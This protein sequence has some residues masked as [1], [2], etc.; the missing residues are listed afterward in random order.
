MA[1]VRLPEWL[2]EAE[3]GPCPSGAGKASRGFAEKNLEVIASFLSGVFTSGEYA[4]GP[5][6]L[7]SVD[8]RARISGVVALVAACAFTSRAAFLAIEFFVI[9]VIAVASNLSLGAV[10]KRVLPSF[11]FTSVLI[12]PAL[13]DFVTPGADI[14]GVTVGGARVS[15]TREGISTAL[16]FLARAAAMVS[17]AAILALTTRHSDFFRGLNGLFIPS[18]FVA[19]LFMAFRYLL[20]LLKTAQDMS[21]ARKSRMIGADDLAGSRGWFSYRAALILKKSMGLS[22]EVNMAMVSRGF[23]GKVRTFE[24]PSL[25]GRDYAWVGFT[26]FMLFISFGL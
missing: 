24:G 22:G 4:S 6:V 15:M 21:L 7:Q 3:K 10:M 8:P 13:F 9:I 14:F 18:I 16:F 12:A 19:T 23:T 17:L 5:G 20:I 26:V 1:E 11:V 2:R 25:S